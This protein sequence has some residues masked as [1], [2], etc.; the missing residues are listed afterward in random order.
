MALKRPCSLSSLMFT[1]PGFGAEEHSSA[2]S[3]VPFP[4]LHFCLLPPLHSS[5]AR[6]G[7][8]PEAL[9]SSPSLPSQGCL[10]LDVPSSCLSLERKVTLLSSFSFLTVTLSLGHGQ[11]A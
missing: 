11:G 3:K 10:F 6:R 9:L 5:Q 4:S 2:S 7:H 8:S 1:G